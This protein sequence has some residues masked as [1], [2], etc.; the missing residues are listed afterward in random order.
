[1]KYTNEQI[2]KMK[3]DCCEHESEMIALDRKGIYQILMEGCVGWENMDE[4]MLIDYWE[5]NC[6]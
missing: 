4:E 3:M 6:G 1:M 5:E 2:E